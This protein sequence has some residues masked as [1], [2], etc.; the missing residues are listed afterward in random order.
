[1]VASPTATPSN[2]FS[3]WRRHSVLSCIKRT[4]QNRNQG[5]GSEIRPLPTRVSSQEQ[6]KS[7]LG[8]EAQERD[9][10]LFLANY[11]ETPY[12]V[13][14]RFVEV[15]S[16][17]D[18]ERPLLNAAIALAKREK[19]CSSFPNWIRLSRRV[20]FIAALMEDRALDFKSPRCHTQTSF[21]STSMP[22]W[23]SRNGLHL[24]AN[25]S[26]TTQRQEQRGTKL[27]A[28]KHH[29]DQLLQARKGKALTEARQVAGV[30]VPLRKQGQTLK[31]ICSVLNTSGLKTARGSRFHSSLVSRMLTTLV[32][33]Q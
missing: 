17:K 12:S 22:A 27:G 2:D 33:N 28:P 32:P 30:I 19:R 6:G 24:P 20:S 10:E 29:L 26:G 13:V 1:M 4:F 5:N 3:T 8:L 21:N 18:N 16:G 25:Q 7:G 15:H 23:Q 11:A 14:E 31:Q 9:I